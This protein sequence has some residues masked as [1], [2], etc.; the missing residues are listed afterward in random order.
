MALQGR[1]GIL[2]ELHH[3]YKSV[4]IPLHKIKR[5]R[6]F[7]SMFHSNPLIYRALDMSMTRRKCARRLPACFADVRLEGRMGLL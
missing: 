6:T 2:R 3:H 1:E 7:N 4:S 5:E